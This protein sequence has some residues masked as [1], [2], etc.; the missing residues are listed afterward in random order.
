MNS[1]DEHEF[2]IPDTNQHFLSYSGFYVKV[3][4][5]ARN[6][7]RNQTK[8]EPKVTNSGADG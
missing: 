8:L 1:G 4:T 6:C 7:Y 5:Q 3:Y 2:I